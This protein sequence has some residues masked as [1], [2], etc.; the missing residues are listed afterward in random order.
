MTKKAKK[1]SIS[2][3]QLRDDGIYLIKTNKTKTRIADPILVTAFATSDPGTPREQAFTVIKFMNR[4]SKWKKEIVSSSMLI[5]HCTEFTTLLSKRGY[6]WP[7]NR[8]LRAKIIVALSVEKPNRDIRVTDVPGW[9]G[10]SFV[11]PGKAYTPD[12]PD[13]NAIQINYNPTVKLGAFQ[14]TGTLDQ[15]K[16]HIAKTCEYSSRARLAVAAVFAAPNLRPLK[17]NTF[18]F[19]F[20][21][22]TSGG[23]TLLVRLAASAAG[24]NSD[25]GPETWDGSA[26]AFEQ[27]ALGHRDSM[28]PLDDLSHLAGDTTQVAQIAKL[29]TFRLASNRPK[30]KAGQYVQAHNLANTDWRVIPLSTSE[31]PL[32]GQVSLHGHGKRR[33]RGEE[34]R[35]INVRACVSDVGDIFDGPTASKRVGGTLDERLRFVEQQE[36]LAVKYQGEAYRAYLAKRAADKTA[37]ATLNKYITEYIKATSLPD[38]FRWLGRIRKFFAVVYASAA[39][40]ID[41]GVLPWSKKSTLKAIAACMTDAMEQMTANSG[42]A[43]DAAGKEIKSDKVLLAEFTQRVDDAKFVRLNRNRANGRLVAKRLKKANGIIRPMSPGKTQCLLFSKTLDGW[44]PVTTERKRLTKMLRS[45]RIIGK[46]RR[47]DTSTRQISIAEVGKKVPC[48]ALSRRRLRAEPGN[49]KAISR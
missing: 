49:K 27:R 17:V 41:Y 45:R 28:M 2:K 30:A 39:L 38:Q 22:P 16:K 43:S 34:V 44:F 4:R 37:I 10:K 23:K 11:L 18:G 33:V 46:G 8:D 24:L 36:R 25:E 42:D 13:R 12:G 3:I 32:W 20:S 26:A 1:A 31:D 47:P 6:V 7:S 29:V 21:D 14:R 48:F 15:W 9:H 5:T 40:A 35:M 19:N